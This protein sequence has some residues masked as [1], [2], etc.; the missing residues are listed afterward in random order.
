MKHVFFVALIVMI[1]SIA[2][3]T[4][5]QFASHTWDVKDYCTTQVGPGPNYFCDENVSVDG[6][7][8]MHLQI[9]YDAGLDAYTCASVKTDVFGCGTYTFTVEG[10]FPDDDPNA[11]L[12]L[13]TYSSESAYDYHEIDIE[14]SRFGDAN[15]ENLGYTTWDN[16]NSTSDEYF[17]DLSSDTTHTIVW[18][19]DGILYQSFIGDTQIT[20]GGSRDEADVYPCSGQD[21]TVRMNFWMF[22]GNDALDDYE[23]VITD[24][25]YEPFQSVMQPLSFD[26][27]LNGSN[28]AVLSWTDPSIGTPDYKVERNLN[29][30]G[31]STLTT[32]TNGTTVYTDTSLQAD[33]VA[34]YRVKSCVGTVCSLVSEEDSVTVSGGDTEGGDMYVE[35]ITWSTG[36]C[37]SGYVDGTIINYDSTGDP[38]HV[39]TWIWVDN[40]VVYNQGADLSPESDGDFHATCLWLSNPG[41]S[42]KIYLTLHEEDDDQ[43][44]DDIHVSS[45]Y[46]PLNQ[47]EGY[48][49]EDVIVLGPF[50][51]T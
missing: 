43:Y 25:N 26:A 7:G 35:S 1:S 49:D 12:G 20:N 24:F 17:V 19:P 36:G 33:D 9:Q 2:S 30:A 37:S 6:N 48:F 27:T 38:R 28:E 14:M 51:T 8:D 18:N 13:F 34:F 5:V 47:W 50:P 15:G 40:D 45:C 46:I 10:G 29:S 21:M 41:S 42:K 16:G 32:I 4:T 31:Y 44:D 22:Q 3:A 11:V 23:I 39:R